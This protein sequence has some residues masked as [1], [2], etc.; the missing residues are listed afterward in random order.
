MCQIDLEPASFS[1]R[2]SGGGDDTNAHSLPWTTSPALDKVVWLDPQGTI[3]CL[4]LELYICSKPQAVK[5]PNDFQDSCTGGSVSQTVR[6][7]QRGGS[8]WKQALVNVHH[9]EMSRSANTPWSQQILAKATSERKRAKPSKIPA[10][11]FRGK[12]KGTSDKG[13][14]E[15]YLKR[16]RFPSGSLLEVGYQVS[17]L[18]CSKSTLAMVLVSSVDEG[19]RAV[20]LVDLKSEEVYFHK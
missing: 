18:R 7:C 9:Q 14:V 2:D 5:L 3:F 19:Q 8:S 17:E 6:T 10:C 11:G 1:G 15:N 13:G 12:Q 4:D 16:L 20:C